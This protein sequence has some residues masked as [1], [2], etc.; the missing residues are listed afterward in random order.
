MR[1][2]LNLSDLLGIKK[3]KKPIKVCKMD[4]NADNDK[5]KY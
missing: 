5:E 4:I 3:P 1:E 2:P